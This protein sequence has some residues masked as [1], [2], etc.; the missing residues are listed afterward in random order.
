MKCLGL[1]LVLACLCA[2]YKKV[3]GR[4]PEGCLYERGVLKCM[5][6]GLTQLPPSLPFDASEMSVF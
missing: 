1:L 5:H 2:H 6:A 3:S 4:Y